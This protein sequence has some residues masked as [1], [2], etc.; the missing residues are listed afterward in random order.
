MKN[1]PRFKMLMAMTATALMLCL[2]ACSETQPVKQQPVAKAEQK[3]QAQDDRKGFAVAPRNTDEKQPPKEPILRIETGMHTAAI[4]RIGVD[5]KERVLVTG[6][7]DKT[8]RVWDIATGEL[9]KTLRVPIADGNE[10]KIG[11]VAISSDGKIIAA[12]GWTCLD[13]DKAASIYLFDT[14]TGAIISRI[15]GLSGGIDHL[16]FSKNGKYLA[17]TLYGKNGL[18]VYE[19]QNWSLAYQDTDYGDTNWWAEFDDFGKLVTTSRDGFIRLYDNLFRLIDKQKPPGGNRPASACFSSDGQKIAVGFVDSTK[20]DVL[21]AKDLSYLYSPDNRSINNGYIASVAWSSDGEFLFAGGG[22]QNKTGINLIR[23]WSREGKGDY[24]DLPAARDAISDILSMKNNKIVFGAA[25]PVFGIIDSD[26]RKTLFKESSIADYRDNLEGFMLSPDGNTVRFGYEQWGKRPAIFST[27]SRTLSESE[28]KT[29]LVSPIT[30]GLEISDWKYNL[31]PKL[32]GNAIKLDQ[33]ETS[34]SLAILPDKK[35]FLLGTEWF[36]RLFDSA[37]NQK[38]KMPVLATTWGVNISG[39]GKKAV[40]AFGDGTI[41]WYRMTDGRAMLSFFPHKD[42]KRWVMWTPSGYYTASPGGEDLIG[43]HINNGKDQSADF[44][45]ASRFRDTYYRPDITEKI[46]VTLDE[47]EA[48]R[49]ANEESG[50]RQ[51]EVAIQ[52]ILPP[53]VIILSPQDGTELSNPEITVAYQADTPSDA[54]ITEVKVLIDGR[55]LSDAK[56]FAVRQRETAQAKNEIR[57]RIPE[58][59]CKVSVIAYNRH[60]AS[61]ESGVSLK[62]KGKTPAPD[63]N[64]LKPT[65]YVLAIG[66]ANYKDTALQLKFAAKDAKDFAQV[67]EKQKG[68]LYRDVVTL[69]KQDATRADVLEGLEWIEKQTTSRDIAMVFLSGHGMNDDHGD[70]YFVP[71]DVNPDK[72]KI[73]GVP[74]SDIKNTVSKNITAKASLLFLDTCHSGNVWGEGR[75]G[76]M[77]DIVRI[78]NELSAVENGV[79]VFASSSGKQY[80]LEDAKW[81]NGAFTK[82]LVEGLGG[83]ADL[84][85]NGEITISLL[86]A[87]I[88]KRVKELTGGRQTPVNNKPNSITDFPIA[89]K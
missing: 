17:V 31:S 79:V 48:I 7:V 22:Y 71:A 45:P 83:E 16:A 24:T 36:L 55:P 67:L 8:V 15:A 54:P 5:A 74:Y 72:I 88:C 14:D 81:N 44:Y 20:I 46:L 80:S 62:W 52:Q 26:G 30:Q 25:D 68:K 23:K 35:S 37:G 38:W 42:G 64:I 32:N 84:F 89:V 9:K 77:T 29:G 59:D 11:A 57:V 63:E 43:W 69:V 41:R 6:S 27:S 65:L 12:G 34:R 61:T 66:V 21:S 28:E 19:T 50:R 13:W 60:A 10:G 58:K 87:F 75:K 33:Y 49:L 86:D 47:K 85:R 3:P 73:T 76:G 70:Y 2:S 4:R 82:A 78:V 18:R 51:Q 56:G 1:T 53:K 40:A 39:D